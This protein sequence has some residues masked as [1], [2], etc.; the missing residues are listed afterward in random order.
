[1]RIKINCQFFQKLPDYLGLG[2]PEDS[3]SSCYHLIPKPPK[4]DETAYLANVGKKLRYGCVL[5][6]VHPEDKDRKFIL[7]YNLGDGNIN[8]VEIATPNSGIASGKFLSARKVPKPNS[9][10]NKPDYYTAKD[11]VIG[12][13]IY[14]YAHRFLITSADLYVYRYMQAHPEDFS[15]EIIQNVRM[16]NLLEGNLRPD[17]RRAIE[18]DQARYMRYQESLGEQQQ[19]V[20]ATSQPISDE[21]IPKP[22]IQEDEV[23]KHYHDQIDVQPAY[24]QGEKCQVPCTINIKEETNIPSDKGVVRFMEPH[25]E[26]K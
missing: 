19:P 16:Y 3:L 10:P 8:I 23:K 20:E 13:K 11:F 24:M 15:P 12:Q 21:R 4:K 22:F 5:D 6:S 25:E 1:M 26:L 18:E 2:T 14:I 17:L 9:N 7:N